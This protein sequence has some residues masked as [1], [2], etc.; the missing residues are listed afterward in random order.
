MC[1]RNVYKYLLN[2]K[3]FV[4]FAYNISITLYGGLRIIDNPKTLELVKKNYPL[5]RLG[6]V[7]YDD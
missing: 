2:I 5:K 4:V 3:N 1:V 7:V 6:Y